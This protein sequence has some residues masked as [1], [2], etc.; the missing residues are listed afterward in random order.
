MNGFYEEM[1]A[2]FNAQFDYLREAYGATAA[3][4]NAMAAEDAEAQERYLAALAAGATEEEA[5]A[6]YWG[7]Q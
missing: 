3:D 4:C 1:E 5:E 2:E 7:A 6:A